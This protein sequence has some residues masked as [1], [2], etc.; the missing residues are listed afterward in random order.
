M[1]ARSRCRV[2]TPGEETVV[3]VAHPFLDWEKSQTFGEELTRLVN[4]SSG[5][6][7]RLDFGKV[8]FVT[9]AALGKLVAAHHQL[10]ASGGHLTLFRVRPVA[11]EIL[12]TTRLTELLDVRTGPGDYVSGAVGWD[13]VCT[14]TWR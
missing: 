13:G 9:A 5:R 4:E 12:R 14:F 1:P 10:R 8:G 3:Q 7:L 11:G 6:T 2:S